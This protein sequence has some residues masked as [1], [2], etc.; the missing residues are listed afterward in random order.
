MHGDIS[1]WSFS[2]KVKGTKYEKGTKSTK[3]ERGNELR[4]K[5]NVRKGRRIFF[6][7]V[8]SEVS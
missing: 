7:L 6:S 1:G 3:Y 5:T 2:F 4:I 8:H